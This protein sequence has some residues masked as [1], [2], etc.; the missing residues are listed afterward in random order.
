MKFLIDM[1]L[2][3]AWVQ[4]L[5][6]AGFESVHWSS[7]GNP[8]APDSEIMDFAR[9]NGLV[10]FTHDLDFGALLAGR[11][12][13]QPSV[14]QIRSQDV[15]PAAMGQIVLRTIQLSLPQLEA[16]ALVTVDPNR[17]RVRIL[18]IRTSHQI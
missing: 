6:G 13:G 17:S 14:I 4:F 3:P 5:A 15:L 16:G 2:S 10:I 18:P 1:N 12:A 9:A 7:V 11:N 8:S